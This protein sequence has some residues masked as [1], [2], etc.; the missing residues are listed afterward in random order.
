[1]CGFRNALIVL[2][3]A[4]LAG[5]CSTV[6][7]TH[8]VGD[9]PRNIETEKEAW[10]GTWYW[11]GE[12]ERAWLHVQVA[13]AARGVLRMAWIEYEENA[14]MMRAADLFLRDAGGWTI[15]SMRMV[16]KP[17][18]TRYFWALINRKGRVITLWAPVVERFCALVRAGKLPGTVGPGA[19]PGDCGDVTLPQLDANHLEL[20]TSETHGLLFDWKSP[21]MLIRQ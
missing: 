18:Q 10:A 20:I 5:G 11:Q 8:P 14:P 9:T 12:N 16:D 21:G 4:L 19:L 17:E 15:A 6:Y 2:C 1:M 13:D 3:V 7:S